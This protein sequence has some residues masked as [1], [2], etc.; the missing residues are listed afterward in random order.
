MKA[1]IFN[2][3]LDKMQQA[4]HN[5]DVGATKDVIESAIII[6]LHLSLLKLSLPLFIYF[7]FN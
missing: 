1:T 5:V 6:F 7:R 4:D 2:E 3:Y